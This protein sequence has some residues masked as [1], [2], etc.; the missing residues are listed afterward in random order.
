MISENTIDPMTGDVMGGKNINAY[1]RLRK[2][3][4]KICACIIL[5]LLLW[6]RE[7]DNIY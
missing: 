3:V 6:E 5:Y 7:R 4:V 1:S 2:K